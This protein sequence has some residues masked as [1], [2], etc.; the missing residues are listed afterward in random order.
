MKIRKKALLVLAPAIMGL[1]TVTYVA[2]HIVSAWGNGHIC[3]EGVTHEFDNEP[4]Y[5]AFLQSHEGATE[6]DCD[7]STTSTTTTVPV[8]TSTTTST[9]T[10]TEVP[11]TSTQPD[12][13]INICHRDQG[14]P[15]WKVIEISE[16]ALSAHLAHQWGEDIYPV[17]AEGCPQPPPPSTTVPPENPQLFVSGECV[18]GTAG[19]IS[20]STSGFNPG[21]SLFISAD[22]GDDTA[23]STTV[24]RNASFT[25]SVTRTSNGRYGVSVWT[26]SNVRAIGPVLVIIDFSSCEQQP[27]T[28]VPQVDV[29]PNLDDVQTEVPEGMFV[30]SKGNCVDHLIDILLQCF[31]GGVLAAVGISTS[32]E[33]ESI[34][35]GI[36]GGDWISLEQSLDQTYFYEWVNLPLVPH[37]VVVQ[38]LLGDDVIDSASATLE[39]GVPPTT[40][41]PSHRVWICHVPPGNPG[42]AHAIEVDE[43]GWNGH[44][45][46]PGD[47][48]L[49][50]PDDPDCPPSVSTTTTVPVTTV[51]PTNPPT[52]ST[53]PVTTVPSTEP[54]TTTVPAPADNYAPTCIDGMWLIT[55]NGP[56]DLTI[57][58]TFVPGA[59]VGIAAGISYDVPAGIDTVWIGEAH[60]PLNR[61]DECSPDVPAT[62][63]PPALPP[64][65]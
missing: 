62:P 45:G 39:C 60:E 49:D 9:T 3:W 6:G 50:G 16:S 35:I 11:T 61:P 8:T 38:L 5:Y 65:R 56:A 4:D 28:T 12:R 64:T 43:N 36:D 14:K 19:V 58:L 13:K 29:C 46:H 37:T 53:V 31:D 40:T 22:F 33:D 54:P 41:V 1:G 42:N 55:N 44:D 21:D 30:N 63:E 10:T 59:A 20:G 15:E 32:P 25:F 27:T 51:P 52:T 47:F 34:R 57:Y 48:L 23:G 17:P 7:E 26:G 2:P 18:S 24:A